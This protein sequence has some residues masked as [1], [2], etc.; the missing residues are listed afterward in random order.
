MAI[1]VSLSKIWLHNGYYVV[2]IYGKKYV[3]KSF[4]NI[5]DAKQWRDLKLK[6]IYD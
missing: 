6:E 5:D 1:T 4:K 3:S 2:R